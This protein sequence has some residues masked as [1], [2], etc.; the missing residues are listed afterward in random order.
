MRAQ[1]APMPRP[2]L[3]RLTRGD[4]AQL[5]AGVAEGNAK[6]SRVEQTGVPHIAHPVGLGG[7]ITLTMKLKRRRIAAKY[8]AEIEE[9]LRQRAETAGLFAAVPSTQPA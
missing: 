7:T 6:L 1:R 8:S 9:P 2:R 3:W 5:A 4:R